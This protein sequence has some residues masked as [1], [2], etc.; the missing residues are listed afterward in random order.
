MSYTEANFGQMTDWKSLKYALARPDSPGPFSQML[1]TFDK[2]CSTH[3]H[4]PN[5]AYS[6]NE[7]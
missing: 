6:C 3:L 4:Q 7:T 5:D 2:T 1:L